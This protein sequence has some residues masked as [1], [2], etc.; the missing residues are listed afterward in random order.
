MKHRRRAYGKLLLRDQEDEPEE[1]DDTY[2]DSYE[3]CQRWRLA[4]V[5][6]A[7]A[8]S[9]IYCRSVEALPHAA[10]A[11]QGLAAG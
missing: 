10:N 11:R 7:H 1:S 5:I 6:R 9:S 8:R 2:Y 3:A 4:I